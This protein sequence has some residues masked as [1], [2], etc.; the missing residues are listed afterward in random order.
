MF[1][2]NTLTKSYDDRYQYLQFDE[3]FDENPFS[4]VII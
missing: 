3:T 1:D 4:F 2:P